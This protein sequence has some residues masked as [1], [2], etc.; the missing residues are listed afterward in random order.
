MLFEVNNDTIELEKKI[1]DLCGK[2]YSI[3]QRIIHKNYGSEKYE[4]LTL[5]SKNLKI[6][7][8]NH[9]DSVYLNFDLR[10]K[11]LVFYFRF[12][13][14]EYVEFCPYNLLT[15]QSSDNSF[16]IQTDQNIYKF[17]II[18]KKNHLKFI[19]KLYNLKNKTEED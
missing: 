2:S 1:D 5:N 11:G 19:Q 18:K 8:E 17:R 3:I 14:T 6:T 12:F 10:E 13:N 4:L 7:L 15:F 9:T 16:T